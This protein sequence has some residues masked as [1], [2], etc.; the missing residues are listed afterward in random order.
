MRSYIEKG[1]SLDGVH[2]YRDIGVII[3]TP[4]Q[5]YYPAK[6]KN[7]EKL[8]GTNTMYD[9]SKLM[10]GVQPYSERRIKILI[11]II[12][13]SN[14]TVEATQRIADTVYNWLYEPAG[15]RRIDLDI[16]PHYY[17]MGEVED[18]N[19][20]ETDLL[21]VGEAEVFFVCYP[22]RIG[23]E[24][25][26]DD[27]FRDFDLVNGI[28]QTTTVSLPP[29]DQLLP[30]NELSVGSRFNIGG[31]S[32]K[33]YNGPVPTVFEQN[34]TWTVGSIVTTT[35]TA[36]SIYDSRAYTTSEN[37]EYMVR[38]QDVVQA[39]N[40]VP[41]ELV[42]PGANNIVPDIGIRSITSPNYLWQGFTIEKNGI[43]YT[44]KTSD[45]NGPIMKEIQNKSFVLTPGVNELKIY[46]SG[47]ELDFRFREERL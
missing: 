7:K 23:R 44:F 18:S 8:I 47:L 30:F 11:N 29:I 37:P 36:P 27:V 13:H 20:F 15:K 26:S 32:Q 19:D 2:S 6:E 41:F 1:F 39:L 10:S 38:A 4:P 35:D 22:F 21:E 24:L 31:W 25:V 14:L 16:E 34:Q 33:F 12:D 9:V 3:P 40:P 17:F 28:R 45:G 46:G 43:M 5:I 42:N